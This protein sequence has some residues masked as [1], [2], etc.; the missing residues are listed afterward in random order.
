MPKVAVTSMHLICMCDIFCRYTESGSD[1]GVLQGTS[2]LAASLD[3]KLMIEREA[4]YSKLAEI[5]D[6][7]VCN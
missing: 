7:M 3:G 4:L 2:G 5:R 6:K 1:F